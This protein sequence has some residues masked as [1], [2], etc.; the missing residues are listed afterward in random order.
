MDGQYDLSRIVNQIDQCDPDVIGLQE[1]DRHL[2]PRSDFDDVI[3]LLA[4]RLD[5]Q[6][7]FGG[8]I[9]REPIRE[10]EGHLRQYGIAV[11]IKN[12]YSIEYS[13]HHLLPK[14]EYEE[15]NSEQ[16]GLLETKIGVGGRSFIFCNT[17]LS[18]IERQ[19]IHQIESLLGITDRQ[20]GPQILVGDFNA[21]P[22]AHPI[23]LATDK[24]EDTAT[25]VG[26]ANAYTYPADEPSHRI[27][28]IFVTPDL[29]TIDTAVVNTTA[30]DH[31]PIMSVLE[32]AVDD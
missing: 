30:S 14:I 17:H 20:S 8:N 19:Q 18:L 9:V 13:H 7:R 28:Y 32:L 29:S 15:R 23:K 21:T 22:D 11:L 3:E 25:T 4:D 27:D 24:Y 2:K 1:V 31:L 12:E 6:Y 26:N 16:R 10:S 5:R